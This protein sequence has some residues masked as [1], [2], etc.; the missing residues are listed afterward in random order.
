MMR[1]ASS[2]LSSYVLGVVAAIFLTRSAPLTFSPLEILGGTWYTYKLEGLEP[3]TGRTIDRSRGNITTSEGE[4]YT[5]LRAVWMDDKPTFDTSW[6]WTKDNL[7]RPHDQLFAWLF[8]ERPDGTY[9][10]LTA[11]AG[12]IRRAMPI[13]VSR[14]RSPS[15]MH[16]GRTRVPH[17]GARPSLA[18]S[19]IRR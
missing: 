2:R 15:P 16:A 5:M 4:S 11:R 10:V 6:Q 17:C 9:G 3:G 14:S 13:P 12:R 19:G 8:G 7:H 18:I 1:P